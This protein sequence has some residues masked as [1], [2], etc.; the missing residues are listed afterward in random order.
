[1]YKVMSCIEVSN[2]Q[3]DKVKFE[4]ESNARMQLEREKNRLQGEL[5]HLQEQFRAAQDALVGS[6][7][8]KFIES[9]ATSSLE[10]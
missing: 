2:F 4:K 9:V 1:M 3:I 8:K 10:F 6:Y 7:Q 5:A